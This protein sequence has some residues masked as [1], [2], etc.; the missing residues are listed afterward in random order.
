MTFITA[1]LLL[2]IT[3][4]IVYTNLDVPL[5]HE[6]T[7]FLLKHF[8]FPLTFNKYNTSRCISTPFSIQSCTS[9]PLQKRNNMICIGDDIFTNIY[10]QIRCNDTF[11]Y[12]YIEYKEWDP[13]INPFTELNIEHY[14]VDY[15][16][17]IVIR[18][19]DINLTMLF[20]SNEIA[21][22][23]LTKKNNTLYTLSNFS[24]VKNFIILLASSLYADRIYKIHINRYCDVDK[25][26]Y[27]DTYNNLLDV[28]DLAK[29]YS[30]YKTYKFYYCQNYTIFQKL[31]HI[32]NGSNI[33]FYMSFFDLYFASNDNNT[34]PFYKYTRLEPK[35]IDFAN[36]TF[37]NAKEYV[38]APKIHMVSIICFLVAGLLCSVYG[39]LLCSV[40]GY[41]AYIN[42]NTKI[43]RVSSEP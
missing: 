3:Q 17:D 26:H 32:T 4:S 19:P 10:L 9:N 7:P 13:L 42:H 8:N 1:L 39:T 11:Y 16:Y 20:Q 2:N 12:L 33:I 43:H 18:N 37:I 35:F 21:N 23:E 15:V 34:I 22:I 30:G 28:N 36:N 25:Q 38:A 27:N 14:N 6:T 5:Y 29:H 41:R 40:Y 31:Q 24:Y